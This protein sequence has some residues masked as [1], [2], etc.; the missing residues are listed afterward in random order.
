MP[1]NINISSGSKSFQNK[2]F[3]SIT[4]L[5]KPSF[6]YEGKIFS[7]TTFNNQRTI[8]LLENNLYFQNHGLI[9]SNILIDYSTYVNFN[10]IL[11][12]SINEY[13]MLVGGNTLNPIAIRNIQSS[14]T[15]AISSSTTIGGN[16]FIDPYSDN[17]PDCPVP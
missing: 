12:Q 13:E 9:D 15:S 14:I 4:K 3:G 10:D 7:D 11:S 17:P 16:S 6:A 8:P 2:I 5:T 1:N